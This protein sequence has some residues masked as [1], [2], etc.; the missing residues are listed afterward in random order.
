MGEQRD[1]PFIRVMGL[2]ELDIEAVRSKGI[3]QDL[4]RII[5]AYA[6]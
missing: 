4:T 5:H 6:T 2:D 3:L 1:N